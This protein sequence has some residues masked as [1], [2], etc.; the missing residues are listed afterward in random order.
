[1]IENHYEINLATNGAHYA[2]VVLP[3]HL[4]EDA[5]KTRLERIAV[6]LNDTSDNE[7]WS[8]RLTRVECVG[9]EVAE[10]KL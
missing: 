5:A 1:M 4:T 6:A 8:C 10:F 9:R 3:S 7:T 2:R